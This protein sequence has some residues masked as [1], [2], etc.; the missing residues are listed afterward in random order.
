MTLRHADARDSDLGPSSFERHGI[1]ARGKD[2]IDLTANA[3]RAL[4]DSPDASVVATVVAYRSEQ[5]AGVL[6]QAFE[7][8][9]LT[10]YTLVPEPT[11]ALEFVK[12]SQDVRGVA[13]LALVDLGGS[14]I[15][16]SIVDVESC[17]VRYAERTEDIGTDV[18]DTLVRDHLVN[19]G[20][21]PAPGPEATGDLIAQ[22]RKIKEDLSA[23]TAVDLLTRSEFE[24]LVG[25]WLDAAASWVS[26]VIERSGQSVS[27]VAVIGG[28]ARIP[29]VR[30][31]LDKKLDYK[32][33]VLDAPELAAARGA[34]LLAARSAPAPA[35]S[36]PVEVKS[37]S[38]P[39]ESGV[40]SFASGFD[41]PGEAPAWLVDEQP[42]APP[43]PK[44]KRS[45]SGRK[46]ILIGGATVVVAAAA[47][48]IGYAVVN[49]RGD[50]N[51]ADT[52]PP[53]T[54]SVTATT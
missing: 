19:S 47:A 17:L 40:V 10:D 15:T 45:G 49:M 20:A 51:T 5:D 21:V 27:A 6:R 41:D 11:A 18:F 7:R 52:P 38:F 46:L 39:A 53:T 9:Q 1:E 36:V 13:R 42:L 35:P 29:L 4:H 26:E 22:C 54:T 44:K 14:G 37:T 2:P 24:R 28:G 25:P 34:A 32:V 43:A 3:I 16:T 50:D 31:T 8:A 30:T 48:G 23:E 33:T 12:A